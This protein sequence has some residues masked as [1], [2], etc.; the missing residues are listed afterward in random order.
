MIGES[1]GLAAAG[2]WLIGILK[3]LWIGVIVPMF[4]FLF[5]RQDKI[6]DDLQKTVY[7]KDET[8]EQIELRMQ[9]MLQRMDAQAEAMKECTVAT[10]DLANA[11]TEFRV[12]V[13]EKRSK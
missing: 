12:E 11:L 4:I 13:A 7:T 1:T 3:Y 6:K 2:K 8:K 9:P 10:K 5:R